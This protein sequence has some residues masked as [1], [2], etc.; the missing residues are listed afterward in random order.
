VTGGGSGGRDSRA[1]AK[2]DA[3]ASRRPDE[4]RG[5]RDEVRRDIDAELAFHFEERIESLV[6]GGKTA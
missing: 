4:S 1:G 3:P 2:R 5:D 6:E